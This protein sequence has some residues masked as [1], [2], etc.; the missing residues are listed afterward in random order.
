MFSIGTR[1]AGGASRT[2]FFPNVEN[3][4]KKA[5]CQ[6]EFTRKLALFSRSAG[7]ALQNLH[8]I[9]FFDQPDGADFLSWQPTG[10][11]QDANPGQADI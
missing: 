11:D 6:V 10:G 4:A 8:K 3:P 7:L 2:N 9:N 5:G 1:I